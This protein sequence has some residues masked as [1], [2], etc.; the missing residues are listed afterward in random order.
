MAMRKRRYS[1]LFFLLLLF[2]LTI[3]APGR[4]DA[5]E[6]LQTGE[7]GIRFDRLALLGGSAATLRYLG[8]KYVDRAW[9]EGKKLDHIRWL[10]DWGGDTYLNLD[11]GGHFMGGLF[12]AQ[13]LTDA[14]TWSGFRPR[15]AALLGTLTSW[16]A[17]LEI[18]M[19]DAH[20]D[21]WGFSIPDF[22][23]NTAGASLPLI[24]A[25]FPKTRVL[26]F[27]FSYHPSVLYLERRE[28]AH[29]PERPHIDHLIDD[30]EGMTFW[31]AL[32]LE[33]FLPERAANRW[34]DFLGLAVGY[35]G[36]GLHGSNVKSKGPNR[37]YPD[38]PDARPEIF[39]ALDYDA[40]FLPGE[41]RLWSYLKTQ[42]NWLH[43]PAPAVRLYPHWRFYLLY[44]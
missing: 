14:Y 44:M 23:A 5:E 7:M 31:L 42:L 18:E 17:L 25:L 12:M 2:L 26:R 19:R 41:G 30:Y 16:A 34:P 43:F 3:H 27:K 9:Y 11:K 28:R 39:L 20:F 29:S 10:N 22:A 40:R 36:A 6:E 8:F 35:G 38:L 33:E 1:S 21:Q 37:R 13:A 4:L 24:H 32:A 15:T